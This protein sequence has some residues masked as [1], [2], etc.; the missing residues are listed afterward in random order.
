[1]ALY[2]LIGKIYVVEYPIRGFFVDWFVA[3]FVS[4]Y[5]PLAIMEVG[6]I[7]TTSSGG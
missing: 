2:T 6:I 7:P 5:K 3:W 4:V 1:M